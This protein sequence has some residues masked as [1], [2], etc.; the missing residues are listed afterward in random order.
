M[1][2][3]VFGVASIAVLVSSS[4]FAADI[5]SRAVVQA[6]SA[7]IVPHNWT[8]LY[9]GAHVGYG[10]AYPKIDDVT[11]PVSGT[12]KPAGVI[13]GGQIGFN[14]QTGASVFGIEA[15][16][17]WGNLDDTSTCA[18]PSGLTLSCRG[19]PTYFGTVAARAGIS[20]DRAMLYVKGGG[21]WVHED[22]TQLGITA[23][24]CVGTPC[25]GSNFVW[26]WTLGGG[27]EY[28]ITPNWSVKVEYNYLDFS[29][30]D[31]VTVTNTVGGTNTFGVSKTM[32]LA[33]VGVNYR[34]D[35]GAR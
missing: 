4:S 11:G 24:V 31:Q 20:F 8:G 14:W 22:F 13:A 7:V 19:A 30:K 34:F 21:A 12:P 15:D 1:R 23:L 16:G 32:H 18:L 10:L 2:A 6:P 3:I 35:W 29:N 28:G 17:T 9:F 5:P 27:L 33:K 25:T 26:G